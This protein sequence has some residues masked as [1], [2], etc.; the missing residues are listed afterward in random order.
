MRNTWWQQPGGYMQAGYYFSAIGGGS[1]FR[2]AL[3]P[4]V[5]P[6]PESAPILYNGDFPLNPSSQATYAAWTYHGGAVGGS[7]T[8]ESG[9]GYLRLGPGTP[10]SVATHNRFFLPMD[11]DDLVFDYR[12][13]TPGSGPTEALEARL[14]DED[15]GPAI[16]IGSI[17][18]N[19]TTAWIDG[20]TMQISPAV[21]RG[22]NYKLQFAVASAGTIEAVAGVDDI[23]I[24]QAPLPPLCPADV[25]G[26][27]AVDIDD[28]LTV[29]NAWGSTGAPGTVP[30]DVNQ[31]GMTDIDDL[32]LVINA[33]GMCA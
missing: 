30:G 6:T 17:A 24:T 20:H 1:A 15:G 5:V 25:N 3:G 32:L 27:G 31:S 16:V 2:A 21:P 29:I 22:R 23:A 19:S 9:N 26:S 7:I 10:G 33:W 28:L 12:V 11:A 8:T 4:G 18:L 13:Y 14:L